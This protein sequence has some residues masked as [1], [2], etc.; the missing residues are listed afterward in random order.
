MY[1]VVQHRVSD[2]VAFRAIG[3]EAL[4]DL[5]AGLRLHQS[6][7][8]AGGT[9]C[10]CLWEADSVEAVRCFLEPRV[11]AV[12]VNEY[13]AVDVAAAVGLPGGTFTLEQV[14]SPRGSTAAEPGERRAP[15]DVVVVEVP[16]AA[17][18]QSVDVP[19]PRLE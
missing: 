8:D 14:V 4:S 18:E 19:R 13:L 16:D 1:V 17:P 3:A 10:V 7:P 9:S 15:L 6:L 5:P 11:G 12:S 2:P